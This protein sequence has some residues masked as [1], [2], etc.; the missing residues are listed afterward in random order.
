MTTYHILIETKNKDDKDALLAWL[1][2]KT[3]TNETF[4]T[5]VHEH[6]DDPG[7]ES[8]D[9]ILWYFSDSHKKIR[10]YVGP[11]QGM[12]GKPQWSYEKKDAAKLS[13]AA[14]EVVSMRIANMGY[15]TTLKVDKKGAT[16]SVVQGDFGGNGKED[17]VADLGGGPD[18]HYVTE[19][20]SGDYVME[21][22]DPTQQKETGEENDPE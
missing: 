20:E 6:D 2:L 19:D 15:K 16:L 13:K 14:C 10:Y 17:K 11:P 3:D 8:G 18:M 5:N 9:Y 7:E 4:E 1:E 12:G 21:E 22:D